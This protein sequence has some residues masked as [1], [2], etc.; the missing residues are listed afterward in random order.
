MQ[1][2]ERKKKKKSEQQET[3]IT[4]AKVNI[5]AP[6]C[7]IPDCSKIIYL[8][9][10]KTSSSLSFLNLNL[11]NLKFSLHNTIAGGLT[12]LFKINIQRKVT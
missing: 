9:E 8:S 5:A 10:I 3:L 6:T 11:A 4:K 7:R 1:K 2:K 12:G